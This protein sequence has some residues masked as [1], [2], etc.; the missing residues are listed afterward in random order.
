MR[1]IVQRVKEAEV[2]VEG[3]TV[4]KIGEGLLVYLGIAPGDTEKEIKYLADK[5]TA[6]RIFEDEN[7]KM[8][9]SLKDIGGEI[10]CISQFTLYADCRKGN[11]PS[12]IAAAP[13]GEAEKLY[14]QFCQYLRDQNISIATGRFAAHMQVKSINN[15]PVTIPLEI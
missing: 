11:R 9:I 5:I 1:A 13:P 6:M 15:G 4:G 7:G 12:F 2:A 10:L 14:N 8:N 3:E